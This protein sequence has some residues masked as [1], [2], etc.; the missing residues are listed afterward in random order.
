M[1]F[2]QLPLL[3]HALWGSRTRCCQHLT[4]Q[5]TLPVS[6]TKISLRT[7]I[8]TGHQNENPTANKSF[9]KPGTVQANNLNGILQ[10]E[11]DSTQHSSMLEFT[12][13][14]NGAAVQ[15]HGGDSLNNYISQFWDKTRGRFP[16]CMHQFF[17]SL[18]VHERKGEQA[19]E[20]RICAL[21]IHLLLLP[22]HLLHIAPLQH[23]LTKGKTI[24]ASW[25]L[26]LTNSNSHSCSWAAPAPCISSAPSSCRTS[27]YEPDKHTGMGARHRTA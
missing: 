27:R 25:E 24:Q 8:F 11:C 21:S 26:V 23:S 5:T 2:C 3:Q 9:W 6:Q 12:L 10:S 17:F 22:E 7:T 4:L 15:K 1:P 18:S 16:A 19:A 14:I 20:R 13:T